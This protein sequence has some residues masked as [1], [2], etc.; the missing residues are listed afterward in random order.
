MEQFSQSEKANDASR[1]FETVQENH[2]TQKPEVVVEVQER[3][4]SSGST[5]DN[6]THNKI[7]DED[8]QIHLEASMASFTK[9]EMYYQDI[10]STSRTGATPFGRQLYRSS[11]FSFPEHSGWTCFKSVWVRV[12]TFSVYLCSFAIMC[13]VNITSCVLNCLCAMLRDDKRRDEESD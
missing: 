11:C 12:I 4:T 7:I 3:P 10:G 2:Q 6:A 8:E 9:N 1:Q 5:A 13:A